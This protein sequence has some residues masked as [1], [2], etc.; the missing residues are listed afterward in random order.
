MATEYIK[1]LGYA[2]GWNEKPEIVK[3]C[4]ELGHKLEGEKDPLYNCVHHRWCPIC[5]YSYSIDSSG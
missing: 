4:E 2:N 5:N 1:D 3:K